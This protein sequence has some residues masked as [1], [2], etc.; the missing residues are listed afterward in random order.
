[1]STFRYSLDK[2]SKK[3]ICP[4][5]N[6][7][8]FV[9]YVDTKTG[10]YL[11]ADYGRCDRE[12]NCKYHKAPPKG[13]RGHLIH[14]LTLKN[15]SDKASKLVDVNCVISMIPNSQILEQN[16]KNCFISEWYLKTST[17]NY[18]RLNLI[19]ID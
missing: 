3:F 4:N 5:C 16:Q 9:F 8:T 12:Q 7:K 14:F 2:S 18:Q 10:N 15:I 19:Y 13:K 1:M 11:P 6:K 17:I